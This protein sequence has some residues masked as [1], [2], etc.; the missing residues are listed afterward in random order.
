MKSAAKCEKSCELQ[1]HVNHRIL[2]RKY[3]LGLFLKVYLFECCKILSPLYLEKIFRFFLSH[4]SFLISLS[5]SPS[6]RRRRRRRRRIKSTSNQVRLPGEL[7]H[8]NNRRKRNKLRC[9]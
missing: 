6:Q 2:E 1:N 5:L 9:P 3:T 4:L 8:F 7:K